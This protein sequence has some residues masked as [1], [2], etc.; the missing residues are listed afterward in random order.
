MGL[1]YKYGC[2]VL[3]YTFAGFEVHHPRNRDP[4]TNSSY[5]DWTASC[6]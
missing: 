3:S 2:V 6:V 1:A 5:S 4:Y